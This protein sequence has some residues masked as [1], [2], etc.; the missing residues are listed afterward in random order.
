MSPYHLVEIPKGVYGEF[1]KIEEEVAELVDAHGQE[2]PVLELC[3]IADLLGAIDAYTQK[4]F[5]L[6]ISDIAKMTELNRK[7]FQSGYR[8]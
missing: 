8:S 3:E 1:S 6:S 2:N 7:A 5:N 4:Y